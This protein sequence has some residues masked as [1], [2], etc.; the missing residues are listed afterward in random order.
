M[1]E[2]EWPQYLKRCHVCGGNWTPLNQETGIYDY[3]ER[4]VPGGY[5]LASSAPGWEPV[6]AGA[7]LIEDGEDLPEEVGVMAIAA[8]GL[9][10]SPSLS[11]EERSVALALAGRL[12]VIE[13]KLLNGRAA[14]GRET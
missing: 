12:R 5:Q 9:A 1:A 3:C 7:L 10:R 6:A 13:A 14:E 8:A 11:L 4:C 2:S